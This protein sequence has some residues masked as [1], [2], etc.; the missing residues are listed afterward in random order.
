ML[1]E[2]GAEL[3]QT[4]NVEQL[5][6]KI[7]DSLFQVFRQADRGF[8]IL[9]EEGKL[10][11]KVIKTRRG[12]EDDSDARFSRKIVNRCLETGQA[13]L[14]EDASVGQAVRPVAEHRRLQDPLGDVRAAA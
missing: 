5:L 13:I 2:L 6:P 7:V 3:S 11:P 9:G 8:I 14:S 1:L 10:I 4:F 12:A